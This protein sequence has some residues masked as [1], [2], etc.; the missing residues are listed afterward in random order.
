MKKSRYGFFGGS[1]NP[2]T[3]AHIKL[4]EKVKYELKLDKVFLVPVGDSYQKDGLIQ[5]KHRVKMLDIACKTHEGLKV[6]DIEAKDMN[7]RNAIQAINLIHE[8]YK[9]NDCFFIMGQDNVEKIPNWE[10][11][12]S[13]MKEFK[14]VFLQ[15]GNMPIEQ[16]IEQKTILKK[17]KNNIYFI[18]EREYIQC[19]S[20]M[21]RD[22]IKKNKNDILDLLPEGV[23]SYIKR[24]HL[25]KD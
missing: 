7:K 22:G 12:E 16:L 8:K 23:F 14:F 18:K 11:S 25:Y 10:F 3:I 15:R 9:R 1:F 17:Y 20:T 6:L 5:A 2:P 24:H 21:V 4:A 19:S 13:L